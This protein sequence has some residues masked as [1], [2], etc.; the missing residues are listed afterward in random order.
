MAKINIGQEEEMHRL[1]EEEN[2]DHENGWVDKTMKS[3]NVFSI[4]GK[5]HSRID[6]EK[7]VTGHANYTHDIKFRGMLHAKILRSPH[8]CADIIS[9]DLSAAKKKAGV[10][11]AIQLYEGRINYAGQQVAAVAAVDVKTAEEALKLIK[12]EYKVLP[13]AV[14]DVKAMEKNAPQV[15]DHPNITERLMYERGDI[16]QGFKEADVVLEQEYRT[17]VQIHQP[18]ET[19]GSIAKWDGKKLTVWDSTQSLFGVQAGLAAAL[20]IPIS[21]VQIIKQYMGGGFGSKLATG[22]YT[23]AVAKL[24]KI[25]R[26]PVKISFSRKENSLCVGNRPS[27]LQAVKAGVKKDGT[28]TALSLHNYSG[29]GLR[30]GDRCAEVWIDIYKCANARAEEY[31]VFSHAGP[32]RPMRAPGHPMGVFS[33]DGMI[34]ALAYEIGMDPLELRMKNYS[35][36]NR[37]DTE[38][39]YSSKKLDQCYK[40]GAEK[41]GWKRR[42][43]KPGSGKG[44]V[45]RGI[46]MATQIWGG[47]GSVETAAMIKLH[48][49][50]SVE[51]LS[52][53][54]D[55]GTGTRTYMA[56]ITADTLGV[57][58]KQVSVRIGSTLYPYSTGSGGSQTTPSV[59]PAVRDAALKAAE[60]L[61]KRA[62]AQLN[63]EP[64]QIQIQKGKYV[65]SQNAE[66]VP[67][68][69]LFARMRRE[70][71]FRG[72]Y[73]G[74]PSEYAYNSFGAHFAE[75]EV[76]TRTGQVKVIK[77]V[78]AHDIGRVLNPLTAESQV[79]G[80]VTQGVS[81]AL[82]EQRIMDD[83]TGTV[84]NPNFRDYKLTT[85][86]D[87]PEIIPIF[88]DSVDPHMSNLGAKG[89]GEPPMVPI[90]A[91]IA[92]A[93]YNA[94]GVH[95]KELPMTPDRILAAL[96]GK[97]AG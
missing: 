72:E 25:A 9:V 63:I 79:I 81:Y 40:L 83:A 48:R 80:G 23:V 59:G 69:K 30:R 33:L 17:H 3:D 39:P 12:V 49:D 29:G 10:K 67:Y 42:K 89:L 5:R 87:I 13:H 68:K 95:V 7:I 20:E 55:I 18:T 78:A 75:V 46:G 35:A 91:A 71:V 90:A 52:G 97:E 8:A 56:M 76:D 96:N 65:N 62:S 31:N 6:G 73:T 26:K 27:T 85:S 19:H 51:V 57:D 50:G 37:G 41:I 34:D 88:I 94:I 92:N 84:L 11:A 32:A 47:A 45:K 38:K 22:E 2:A 1:Y 16:D 60:Y 77:V 53:T 66:F 14:S 54:Q 82:F 28:L 93:V 74:R 86:M 61:K 24:A 43:K 58:L 21:D 64:D 36:K 4:V 44:P 15:L 70:K